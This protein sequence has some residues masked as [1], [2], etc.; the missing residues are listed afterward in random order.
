MLYLLHVFLTCCFLQ[1]VKRQCFKQQYCRFRF[2]LFRG[3]RITV[4]LSY[5]NFMFRCSCWSLI[6][7]LLDALFGT[8]DYGHCVCIQLCMH[9]PLCITRVAHTNKTCIHLSW[10]SP[11][12][13]DLSGGDMLFRGLP[14]HYC[15]T[16]VFDY[17]VQVMFL[18]DF[19]VV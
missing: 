3:V 12:P 13:W 17:V 2:I 8:H 14:I 15:T 7:I 19:I 9:G 6:G 4:L 18:G 5:N 11:N 1:T 10:G 16:S